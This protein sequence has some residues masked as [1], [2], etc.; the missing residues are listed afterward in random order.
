MLKFKPEKREPRILSK[1]I[2][3]LPVALSASWLIYIEYRR[4]VPAIG[5][6]LFSPAADSKMLVAALSI[7]I[8]YVFKGDKRI[9]L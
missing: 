1:I 9:F 2:L 8:A 7:F 3:G 6:E 4:R 5:D